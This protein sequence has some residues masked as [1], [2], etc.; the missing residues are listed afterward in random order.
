MTAI[1]RH[2]TFCYL[3]P[4]N[5]KLCPV[6][7][8]IIKN[9]KATTCSSNCANKFF[10][11]KKQ[12]PKTSYRTICF[13]YHEKKCIVCG[14]DKIVSVHHY[15]GNHKNNDPCN[16]IPLCPTHHQYIHSKYK[17]FVLPIINKYR[18]KF[19]KNNNICGA[20]V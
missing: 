4:K 5:K 11:K 9:I 7:G 1:K 6:C 17:K 10:S 8:K 18:K 13:E 14:E 2:E 3:N 20:V 16:L 19:I 12:K 15:D